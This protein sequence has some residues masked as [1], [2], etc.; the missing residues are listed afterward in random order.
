MTACQ[1]TFS[2][3]KSLLLDDKG[4]FCRDFSWQN[5]KKSMIMLKLN[6]KKK[7]SYLKTNVGR[8]PVKRV[9]SQLGFCIKTIRLNLVMIWQHQTVLFPSNTFTIPRHM[10]N[11]EKESVFFQRRWFRIVGASS[12]LRKFQL[13]GF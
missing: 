11:F 1:F 2:I 12:G 13:N 3:P 8:H 7:T 5:E 10:N 6:E 9:H 4:F